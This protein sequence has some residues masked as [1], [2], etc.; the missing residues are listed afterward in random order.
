MSAIGAEEGKGYLGGVG[1]AEELFGISS[2]SVRDCAYPLAPSG[3]EEQDEQEP[4]R[5][6]V[7]EAGERV[8]GAK[9]RLRGGCG[10]P[11]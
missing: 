4:L 8:P 9:A 5:T 7:A 6:S 2:V 10:C 3:G 1:V 11:G